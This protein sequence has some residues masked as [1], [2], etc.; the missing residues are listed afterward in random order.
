VPF[1]PRSG[2]PLTPLTSVAALVGDVPKGGGVT[3]PPVGG[4][5]VSAKMIFPNLPRSWS[6]APHGGVRGGVWGGTPPPVGASGGVE[7]VVKVVF[8]EPSPIVE[9]STPWGGEGGCFG[10]STSPSPVGGSL[11]ISPLLSAACSPLGMRQPLSPGSIPRSGATLTPCSR[12][13]FGVT[14]LPP[15]PCTW[16][17][18]GVPPYPMQLV[19]PRGTPLP[20]SILL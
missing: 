16:F 6:W 13:S 8:P 9:S 10:G 5:G 7:G 17:R 3:P 11:K 19:S 1:S 14:P 18:H 2:H 12:F 4:V 20:P 15:T